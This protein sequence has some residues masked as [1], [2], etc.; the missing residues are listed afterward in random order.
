MRQAKDRSSHEAIYVVLGISRELREESSKAET[1]PRKT[2]WSNWGQG[3][4]AGTGG[5]RGK[6]RGKKGERIKERPKIMSLNW[7]RFHQTLVS[8]ELP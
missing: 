1:G 7:V 2:L 6:G 4:S 5:H 3:G 8:L